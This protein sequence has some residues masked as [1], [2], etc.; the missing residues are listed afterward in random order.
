M[1]PV[2][3]NT[4]GALLMMS[5]MV[6]FTLNDAVI[7]TLADEMPMLQVLALRGV[8]TTLLLGL[9]AY[10]WGQLRYRPA[11]GDGWLIALRTLAEIASAWLFLTALFNMPLANVSAIM[12]S[13]PLAVTLGGALV[14][15]EPVGW[16]RMGAILVGFVG[17]LLIVQPGSD[18][19]TGYSL[20]ALFSVAWVTVRDLAARR[21]ARA[22]PSVF[23]ALVT[24]VGVTGFALAGSVFVDWQPL[25]GFMA[26][27]LALAAAILVVGYICLVSAMRVGEIGLVAPFRYASLIAALVLG[28]VVFGTFPGPLTLLGAAIVVATGLFTLY[29]ER[30]TRRGAA[31]PTVATPR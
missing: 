28:A 6:A 27:R 15:R 21:M 17:V 18:G 5:G 2:S 11:R 24:S 9:V 1:A 13:L 31:A 10:R 30:V 26:L 3:D 16:R 14:L 20:L 8:M 22:V 29:R 19:F 25:T 4:R 7:K 12:Q 23:V